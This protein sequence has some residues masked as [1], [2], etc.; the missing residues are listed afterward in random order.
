MGVGERDR[1]R[2]R[3]SQLDSSLMESHLCVPPHIDFIKPKAP[4]KGISI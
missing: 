1:E 2:S 3:V 4:A